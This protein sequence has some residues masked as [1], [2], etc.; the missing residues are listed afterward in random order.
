MD[1]AKVEQV[2]DSAVFEIYAEVSVLRC[3][4]HPL[5]EGDRE[6]ARDILAV[7]ISDAS[8][9]TFTFVGDVGL[10]E[11][12]KESEPV[13]E[14]VQAAVHAT[15][16]DDIAVGTEELEVPTVPRPTKKCVACHVPTTQ[17]AVNQCPM[18]GNPFT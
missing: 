8:D 3:D 15:I 9:L 10:I 12:K 17:L 18:C 14:E 11:V 7:A 2:T 13:V 5:D 16:H 6:E 4:E 1:D